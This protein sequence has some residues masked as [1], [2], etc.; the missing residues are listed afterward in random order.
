MPQLTSSDFNVTN[1]SPTDLAKLDLALTYLQ[2]SSATSNILYGVITNGTVSQIQ[3]VHDGNDMY[4]GTTKILSWDPDSALQITNNGSTG[5]QSAAL[6]LIHEFAHAYDPNFASETRDQREDFATKMEGI[7]AR[8][9]DE[10]IRVNYGDARGFVDQSNPTQHTIFE[11]GGQTWT[12]FEQYGG[13]TTGMVYNPF[14]SAAPALGPAI[15]PGAGQICFGYYMTIRD[16]TQTDSSGTPLSYQ[17]WVG[18]PLVMNLKGGKIET[19]SLK[20]STASFDMSGNGKAIHTS[21]ITENEGF[22]VFDK[23]G[24]DKVSSVQDLI[25]DFHALAKLDGNHDGKI[26]ASDAAWNDLKIWVDKKSDGVFHNGEL[27]TMNQL[28]VAEIDL[29][30]TIVNLQNHGNTIWSTADFVF[31][32]G[33]HGTIGNVDLLTSQQVKVDLVGLASHEAVAA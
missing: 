6:G 20:D 17:I 5:V 28:S 13:E 7:V 11:N 19:T 18:D 27:H 22:L 32:D 14:A 21:W 2:T 24:A 1:A 29:H 30:E 8:D 12:E 33:S 15:D 26:N 23:G 3:I 10:P 31:E 9:L 25:P 16:E 4:N